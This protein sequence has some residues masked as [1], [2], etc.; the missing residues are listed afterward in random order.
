MCWWALASAALRSSI[1]ALRASYSCRARRCYSPSTSLAAALSWAAR[2]AC[3]ASSLAWRVA[4]TS[5]GAMGRSMGVDGG[6]EGGVVGV[7]W[8][9]H[10]ATA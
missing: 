8:R 5:S 7:P 10:S 6:K 2:L 1:C 3:S 4:V 9:S